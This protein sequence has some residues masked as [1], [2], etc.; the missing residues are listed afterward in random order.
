MT[1]QGIKTDSVL[2]LEDVLVATS[3]SSW[4]RNVS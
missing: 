1:L 2:S 4:I 3:F